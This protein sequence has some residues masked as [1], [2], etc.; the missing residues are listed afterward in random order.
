MQPK[1]CSEGGRG[2]T[3]RA[4]GALE[5]GG[6]EIRILFEIKT[7]ILSAAG[8]D[9]TEEENSVQVSLESGDQKR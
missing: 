8:G 6:L 5:D 2:L 7:K 1:C 3:P 4:E 9:M